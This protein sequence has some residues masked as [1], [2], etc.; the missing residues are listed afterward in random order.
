MDGGFGWMA[1]CSRPGVEL[2][3][4]QQPNG[5]F[6]L[7]SKPPAPHLELLEAGILERGGEVR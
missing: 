1:W 4:A 5:F 3:A 2:T 7:R 6:V